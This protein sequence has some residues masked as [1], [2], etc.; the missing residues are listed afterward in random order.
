MSD[1]YISFDNYY[2]VDTF[3]S[4]KVASKN[5]GIEFEEYLRVRP[6]YTRWLK[7]KSKNDLPS[8]VNYDI[9]T[10]SDKRWLVSVVKPTKPNEEY[11]LRRREGLDN[12]YWKYILPKPLQD[13]KKIKYIMFFNS[14]DFT[15]L[16]KI[17]KE[18]GKS[19]IFKLGKTTK[20]KNLTIYYTFNPLIQGLIQQSNILMEF[21]ERAIGNGAI[22]YSKTVPDNPGEMEYYLNYFVLINEKLENKTLEAEF[23]FNGNINPISRPVFI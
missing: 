11:L 22:K 17:S 7:M 10:V 6:P 23:W 5:N 12:Q 1:L 19:K 3:N 15:E 13:T 4:F 14:N 20:T 16:S 21:G 8:F 9:A 2:D 18:L